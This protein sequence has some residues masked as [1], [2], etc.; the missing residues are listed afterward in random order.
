MDAVVILALL[1]SASKP[2]DVDTLLVQQ[3]RP[4]VGVRTLKPNFEHLLF[5]YYWARIL[6]FGLSFVGFLF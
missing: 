6:N 3:F 4:P 1:R 2:Q 5:H